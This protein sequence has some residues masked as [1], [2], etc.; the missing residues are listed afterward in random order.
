MGF[1]NYNVAFCPK[2]MTKQIGFSFLD[3]I[4]ITLTRVLLPRGIVGSRRELGDLT[5]LNNHS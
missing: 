5:Y 4:V 2:L 3:R 1:G